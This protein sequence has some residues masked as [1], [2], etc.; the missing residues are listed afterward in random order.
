MS[1]VEEWL[2]HNSF[3]LCWLLTMLDSRKTQQE[4]VAGFYLLIWSW[5]WVTFNSFPTS[6]K[7]SSFIHFIFCRLFTWLF[8]FVLFLFCFNH[9]SANRCG[10]IEATRSNLGINKAS[11]A[12][13]NGGVNG[14]AICASYFDYFN[15]K[16]L[17]WFKICSFFQF[18]VTTSQLPQLHNF[19]L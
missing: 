12:N 6:N 14:G 4:K 3:N 15:S 10:G 1:S 17:L 18:T 2:R 8:C 13:N 7:L 11:F 9:E 16:S 5:C 19:H